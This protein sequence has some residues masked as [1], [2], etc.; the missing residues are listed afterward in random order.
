MEL[1]GKCKK[2]FEKWV[3]DNIKDSKMYNGKYLSFNLDGA[4]IYF[5][6]LFPSMQ[7]GMIQDFADSKGFVFSIEPEWYVIDSDK[8]LF[9]FFIHYVDGS[10]RAEYGGMNKTREE[11]MIKSIEKFDEIYNS[12]EAQRSAII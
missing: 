5:D 6:D 12:A 11:A 2:D 1:T 10:K 7:F 3:N 8:P 4:Y 9:D